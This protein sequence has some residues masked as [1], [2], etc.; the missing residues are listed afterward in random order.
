MERRPST[1]RTV[2]EMLYGELEA[3]HLAVGTLESVYASED[4]SLLVLNFSEGTG[5]SIGADGN[6]DTITLRD[7]PRNSS[8][9]DVTRNEV[10]R[11]LLGVPLFW[12]WLTINQ[13]G[14]ADGALL[15]FRDVKPDI[16]I[17]VVASSLKVAR[18]GAWKEITAQ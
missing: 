17:T 2:G 15:S 13:K 8:G 18:L 5:L 7:N 10:W 14:Y 9:I 4:G 16:C 11:D 6:T 3:F 1:L 12:G